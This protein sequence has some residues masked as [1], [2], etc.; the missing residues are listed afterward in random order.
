[1]GA[2]LV[3]ACTTRQQVF[4]AARWILAAQL[5]ELSPVH[6]RTS[7]IDLLHGDAAGHRTDQRAEVAAHAVVFNDVRHVLGW[8][9]VA[10]VAKRPRR[11]SDALMRAIFT[12]DVTEIAAD[13]FFGI[14]LGDDFVVE[15]KVA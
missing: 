2:F 10:Q 13:T 14:D 11:R 5:G 15:V 12:G 1:M 6:W 4:R 8:F 9:T 3:A 7:G